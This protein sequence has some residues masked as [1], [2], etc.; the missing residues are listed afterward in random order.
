M[1]ISRIK[2][3][4][5][6]TDLLEWS[7][8]W[9]YTG[10][11][12]QVSHEW[13]DLAQNRVRVVPNAGIMSHLCRW[14]RQTERVPAN[15][16]SFIL[17]IK[18]YSTR[19]FF[20]GTEPTQMENLDLGRVLSEFICQYFPGHRTNSIR[21]KRQFKPMF[22]KIKMRNLEISINTFTRFTGNQK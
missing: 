10:K 2:H 6:T 7:V 11:N 16:Q 12:Y 4:S 1:S 15:D 20:W 13:S 18:T 3:W 14:I 5:Q 17:Y 8:N 19:L 9:I 22:D 21:A